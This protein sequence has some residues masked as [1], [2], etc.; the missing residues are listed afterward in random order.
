[1]DPAQPAL[2]SAF[3][4]RRRVLGL[5]CLI[6]AIY[7]LLHPP[8][9]SDT[10]WVIVTLPDAEIYQCDPN[11]PVKS[12]AI[13]GAGSGGAST[14]YYLNRF[15][16][17]CSRINITVYERSSYVG[18]RSTT[19]EVYGDPTELVEL[20][21][22]IFVEVNKN[23]VSAAREFGLATQG[24]KPKIKDL[25][26]TLGVYDGN[27]WAFIGSESGWWT[28]AKILWKYGLAPIRTQQLM[29]MTVGAFLK[30]YDE[31]HFPFKDLSQTAYDVGL[32]EA[33]AA[34]GEQF[35]QTNGIL[36]SFGTDIIQAS[37]RVNYAQNIDQIHGLESM[38][39]MATDGAM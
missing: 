33:T 14:A 11:E 3:W 2:R 29:K 24:F 25:P 4:S 17:P 9:A 15:K 8:S 30:M 35:L 21:A 22:S 36:G 38:V 26:N 16:H 32:T 31:P 28:T 39:C 20:G 5:I 27:D 13:V 23:L 18:G 34:T 37:T 19:V 1:M 10:E 6:V 7:L 12:V